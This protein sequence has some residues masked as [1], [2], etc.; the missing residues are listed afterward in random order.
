MNK[1]TPV[2]LGMLLLTSYFAGMNFT[3]LESQGTIKETGARAGADPS[4]VAITSPKETSCDD[5]NGCRN[6]IQVGQATT[7][8]AFIKNSGDADITE[9]TYSVTVYL[10]DLNGN[11]GNIA[12]DSSGSDLSWSNNDAMCDDGTV[13]DYD[14][15]VAPL[16]Q[17]AFLGGGKITLQLQGGA[18]D[19]TWTPTQGNYV[20]E[21]EVGGPEDADVSNNNQLVYVVVEDWYDIEVDLSWTNDPNGNEDSINMANLQSGEFSLSVTA[22]GSEI[23][24]PREVEVLIVVSGD[25]SSA[26]LD[27]ANLL[28]DDQGNPTD[29]TTITVGTDTT[30]RTFE[31][32]DDPTN[33]TEETRSVLTYQNTE[34]LNGE[35]VPNGNSD[36]R[37]QI[38]AEIIGYTM[39]GQFTDCEEFIDGGE[40]NET[41]STTLRHFCEVSASSDDRPKT[42]FDELTGSK[43]V[44]DDIRI[45]RMGVYQG[46]NYDEECSGLPATF[47][48]EGT[49]ADL[50]VGCAL[51]YADVE[52]RGSDFEK[53][54]NWWVNYT[55]S[56]EDSEI[57]TVTGTV[58]ECTS[59]LEMP[60]SFKP[61]GGMGDLVGSACTFVKLVPGEY[62]FTFELVMD[63]KGNDTAPIPWDA[64]ADGDARPSNN[65][66]TM[67]ADVLNN[68]PVVTAFELVTEGDIVVNQIEGLQLSVNAFD[69]DD[70]S[71][72]GLLFSYN[73]QGGAI[74]GCGG[75][76]AEGGTSCQTP[77]LNNYI[78]NLVVTVIVTDAH[79]DEVS[80]EMSIDVWNDATATA[81]TAS[82]VSIEYPLQYFALSNFTIATFEDLDVS[83]YSGQQLEGFSGTYD[84]V[85]A[86][87]YAPSTTFPANDILSQSLSVMVPTSLEATSLWYIDGSGKWILFSDVA[88]EVDATTEMFTYSVPAN[89]PVVPAGKLI[90][91]GGELAQA[92]IPDASVSGFSATAQKGG[93]IALAWD[94]TGTL[95]SSDSIT[96]H[97]CEAVEDCDDAF[98]QNVADEDRSFTYSGA[99]TTHGET[100]FVTVAVCN[101][102]G[103]ST[104]GL[105]T[106]VADKEVDGDYTVS[107]LRIEVGADGQ[108]W[109][110][111]WDV[112]GDTDDV[113]M[114]HICRSTDAFDLANMPSDCPDMVMAGESTANVAMPTA[115]VNGKTYYFTVVGMDNKGNMDAAAYMNE[116]QDV[117]TVDNSNAND[118]NGTIGDDGDSASSGIPMYAWG[119]IAGV[120]VVA[121]VVGAFILSRGDGEGGEGKDWDY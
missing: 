6:T 87:D 64:A 52:H 85:A 38:T 99:S 40:G 29:R 26:T 91:M 63:E 4:V 3:E 33:F 23:F 110:L 73:Y 65:D 101:E 42:D 36:A 80:Q 111:T 22:N 69:V 61:L 41:N 121:F 2:L 114:W 9:L 20:V 90:L 53:G 46:Y 71:G 67:V 1:M 92:S 100:Y 11:P 45:S 8:S 74:L 116:A 106:V 88:E 115:V 49:G 48:Q 17:G 95:L 57:P 83:A 82:G 50:N 94:I 30:V 70:P 18:G 19:I 72:D 118:G 58:N 81:S 102:E 97:I 21:V 25:Y 75:T 35:F 56:H 78:G 104:P 77:V 10:A 14:S 51:V 108:S 31:H 113:A 117:R 86:V 62:T 60:Y 44:Y 89:S 84:A 98:M 55:I 47:T 59:G 103:C 93:A 32:Q 66:V 34:V 43:S 120:V 28:L 105:A 79:G 15:S 16:A 24:S 112:S 7:F 68:L 76:Q 96:V 27:G 107:N 54:Y 119:M 39:Y 13:C 37:F 109:D 5:Q 12:K